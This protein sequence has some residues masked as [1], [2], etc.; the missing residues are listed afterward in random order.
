[1]VF[2]H[3]W[4]V[5]WG[6]PGQ[7]R[8]VRV[9]SNCAEVELFV[10]GSSAGKRTRNVKDFPCAGL[11]WNVGFR[12]GENELRAV[13]ASN[14]QQVEDTVSFRYKTRSRGLPTKFLLKQLQRNH[15]GTTV[16]AELI[17]A[18]GVRCLDARN[19]VRF[20]IA[21]DGK[22][23][24]NLGTPTGSRVVQVYNGRAELTV[25]TNGAAVISVSAAELAP[26]FLAIQ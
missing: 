25:K 12:D 15:E 2:G 5:R 3:K 24:D 21:G 7:D 17:D 8:L 16:Q 22:M 19:P 18:A 10:N 23:L 11:R 9:Y 20:E 4:P 6:R 14:G 13:A 26:V 1:M